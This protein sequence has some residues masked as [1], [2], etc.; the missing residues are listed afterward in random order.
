V[1]LEW[2]FE[3]SEPVNNIDD[4]VS[5]SFLNE[6]AI[7]I[8]IFGVFKD[9]AENRKRTIE[10]SEVFHFMEKEFICKHAP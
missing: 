3:L 9:F 5:N 7:K 1:N 2:D 8:F 4:L 6:M 10:E